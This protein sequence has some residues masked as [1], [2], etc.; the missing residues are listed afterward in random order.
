MSNRG[1]EAGKNPVPFLGRMLAEKWR[2]A[3]NETTT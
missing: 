1:Q 3:Y 2:I